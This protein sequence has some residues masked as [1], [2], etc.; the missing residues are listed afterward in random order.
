MNTLTEGSSASAPS[1]PSKMISQSTSLTTNTKSSS[2]TQEPSTA[3][4]QEFTLCYYKG[5]HDLQIIPTVSDSPSSN[6]SS[7]S[8]S[9]PS[10]TKA[11][12]RGS[13]PPSPLY[14][15]RHHQFSPSKPSLILHSATPEGPILGVSKIHVS[16]SKPATLGLGD[17]TPTSTSHP[18]TVTWESL[19]RTSMDHSSHAISFILSASNER[20]TFLWRRTHAFARFTGGRKS[21]KHMKLVE[22]ETGEVVGLYVQCGL[23]RSWR[24]KGRMVFWKTWGEEWE[25]WVL[26]AALT[27]MELQR[28]D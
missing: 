15:V 18:N 5:H 22:E 4:I 23:M 28:R 24:K 13:T 27:I 16:H 3:Y 26:L 21:M 25:K 9:S 12:E 7:S 1:H 19:N 11:N 8:S 6:A 17:P 10:T 14:Y 20:K 2:E